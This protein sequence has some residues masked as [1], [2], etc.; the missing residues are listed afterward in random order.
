M[1]EF[2]HR[3]YLYSSIIL[4]NLFSTKLRISFRRDSFCASNRSTRTGWV[5]EA[6]M[7]AHPSSNFI[8]MPSI[9]MDS[10]SSNAFCAFLTILNLISSG[11]S[12]LIS[13]VAITSGTSCR[14]ALVLYGFR[15]QAAPLPFS[16]FL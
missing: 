2:I 3:L 7:S 14:S 16:S 4:F 13:G 9:V 5:L 15:L 11:Q 6:R 10:Y 12:T 8:L 1:F